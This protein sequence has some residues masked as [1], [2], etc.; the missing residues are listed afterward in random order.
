MF[1]FS[2]SVYQS[3]LL[4]LWVLFCFW[5]NKTQKDNS[6]LTR[7]AALR[8][9]SW[10]GKHHIVGIEPTLTVCKA[11]SLPTILSLQ[12]LSSQLYEE[13]KARLTQPLS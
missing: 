12:A 5:W 6:D 4:F 8:A 2:R 11:N 7:D 13:F 3:S 9:P 1:I 10:W